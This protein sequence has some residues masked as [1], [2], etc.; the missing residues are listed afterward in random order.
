MLLLRPQRS[1]D[2]REAQPTFRTND[3]S[4]FAVT[5]FTLML[6]FRALQHTVCKTA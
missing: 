4:A 1:P 3:D 2:Q 6:A 5:E